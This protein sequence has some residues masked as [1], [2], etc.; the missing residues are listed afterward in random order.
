MCIRDSL[1]ADRFTFLSLGEVIGSGLSSELGGE[2]VKRLMSGGA[3]IG[4]LAQELE[5]L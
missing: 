2:D 1:I 5:L 4:D 3:K